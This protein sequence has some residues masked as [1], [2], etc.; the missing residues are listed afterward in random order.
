MDSDIIVVDEIIKG[1]FYPGSDKDTQ[2]N[3][4]PTSMP[5][6][7]HDS[8]VSSTVKA[9]EIEIEDENEEDEDTPKDKAEEEIMAGNMENMPTMK[10]GEDV[11]DA[12]AGGAA[13]SVDARTR[14]TDGDYGQMPQ[15]A[16]PGVVNKTDEELSATTK[17]ISDISESLTSA[18]STLA[19]TVKALDARI[20]GINKA[21]SGIKG[22]VEN[23][24]ENFGKR[25]DAVEKD[26]A[27]RKSADLGEILQEQPVIM[28]KSM[29]LW[30]GRF[31]TNA[32]L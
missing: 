4:G 15:Q 24:K 1:E 16:A 14:K 20:E 7:E 3:P 32:D 30:G 31:L 19:E 8:T 23:V 10:F 22:E 18:L 6:V 26:T 2:V 27:F 29:N 5:V 21:V 25:V 17:M 28:E 11:S 9:V 13:S 12:E